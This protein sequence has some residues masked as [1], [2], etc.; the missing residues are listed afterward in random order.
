M[1][2]IIIFGINVVGNPI[3]LFVGP[4][5]TKECFD[6][7]KRNLGLDLPIYQQYIVFLKNAFKGELGKGTTNGHEWTLIKDFMQPQINKDFSFVV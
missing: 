5:C 4:E 3:D 1:T 2:L 7:I 6:L